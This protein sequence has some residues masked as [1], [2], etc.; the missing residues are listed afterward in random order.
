MTEQKLI[1]CYSVKK[2]QLSAPSTRSSKDKITHFLPH[3][4]FTIIYDN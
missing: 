2:G 4:H 1:F 3:S